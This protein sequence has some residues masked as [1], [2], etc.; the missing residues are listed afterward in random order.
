MNITSI[1][2]EIEVNITSNGTKESCAPDGKQWEGNITSRTFLTKTHNLN[3]IMR[4]HWT[5]PNRGAFYTKRWSII[6]FKCQDDEGQGKTEKLPQNK[7]DQKNMTSRNSLAV[8]WLGLCTCTAEGPGFDLWSGIYSI[9]FCKPCRTTKKKDM[10]N[11]SKVWFL[12]RSFAVKG[13]VVLGQLL[14]P[15]LD[16]KLRK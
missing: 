10:T 2:Q 1:D 16:L 3:L 14:K 13:S 5:N 6:I 9:R 4:K 11:K 8:Q 15:K 12:T 7:G